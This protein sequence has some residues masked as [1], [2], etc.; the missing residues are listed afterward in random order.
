MG[1]AVGNATGVSFVGMN[2]DS[3]FKNNC[4]FYAYKRNGLQLL[5][6]YG[7]NAE[8]LPIAFRGNGSTY[9]RSLTGSYLL[10]TEDWVI[11]FEVVLNNVGSTKDVFF[12]QGFTFFRRNS[13]GTW[14]I[15]IHDGSHSRIG[16]ISSSTLPTENR[17]YSFKIKHDKDGYSQLYESGNL[18]W[19]MGGTFE[20][21]IQSR[22]SFGSNDSSDTMHSECYLIM[23]EVY[24]DLEETNLVG[25]YIFT[26]SPYYEY[27][28]SGNGRN[29]A[30]L[31][32]DSSARGY[33]KYGSTYLMDY[34]YSLWQK[35]GSL[36]IYVPYGGQS[37]TPYSG[38]ELV[39]VYGGSET[40]LNMA[41]CLIGFNE[42]ESEDPALQIF[43]RSNTTIQTD[44][45]RA[46]Q[47]YD[48]TNLATKSRY[49]ISELYPYETISSLFNDDYKDIVFTTI[50]KKGSDFSITEIIRCKEKLT[51]Y[52]LTKRKQLS[53]LDGIYTV[54]EDKNFRKIN[55]AIA[56]AYD[57]YT[58]IIDEGTYTE[59]IDLTT[60]LVNLTGSGNRGT[61]IYY[62]IESQSSVSTINVAKDCKFT[63]LII[64]KR[65]YFG[66][67]SGAKPIVNVSGC[68]PVF[69]NCQ[70]G[71]DIYTDGYSSQR[72]MTI[73]NNSLVT[74]NNCDI[75][76]KKCYGIYR[77]DLT[78]QDTSKLYFE[79][80]IFC[81]RLYLKDSAEAYVDTDYLYTNDSSFEN[82]CIY[83]TGDS[84][85]EIIVNT[86]E[87]SWN[88]DT[89]EENPAGLYSDASFGL[90]DNA[91][92]KLSGNQI[93]GA[94]KIRGAGNNVLFENIT[95][96]LGH[97]W[98]VTEVD[99]G[100]GCEIT[101]D[102]CNIVLDCDNDY[103]GLHI[104]E[105]TKGATVNILNSVLEFSGH[106]GNW[107]T[108]GNPVV[109]LGKLYMRN[110]QVID[111]CN[112]N[113]PFGA[114]YGCTVFAGSD[115]EIE[116][117]V[118][119]NR[120]WDG[121][122][123]NHNLRIDKYAGTSIKVR[124]KNVVFNNSEINSHPL[125]FPNG[126]LSLPGYEEDDYICED[127]VTYNSNQ[128]N[129][130]LDCLVG[131]R[132]DIYNFLISNCPE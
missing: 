17:K 67:G 75:L 71:R 39:K 111:N 73:A 6:Y 122:G 77:Y 56:R 12:S 44:A 62:A 16:T 107:Y 120:N 90:Y 82:M 87:I 15:Q 88:P 126:V 128:N 45:S 18:L 69:T 34:G 13:D 55:Q 112:D 79:G 63:N 48:S 81:C 59:N 93:T 78:I 8:I 86:R 105:D 32:Y 35:S 91:Y 27:D 19:S 125:F 31:N 61:I 130:P 4:S 21:V 5:D 72:P 129:P 50:S 30:A 94:I 131:N 11:N 76:A 41:P 57:N 104:I 123:N 9:Y 99:A 115:I 96:T 102:N 40:K 83:L 97:F 132:S 106:N 7:N 70:I 109:V 114:N 119:T 24:S 127:N 36:D 42:S 14:Y 110:S 98:V 28:I 3:Y 22:T 92:L 38:Y 65:E 47:Y 20:S 116:D 52:K 58:I 33:C 2:W 26:G 100:S 101:F 53:H 80:I 60:K 84:H 29:L 43:D 37:T 1:I 103:S 121:V 89:R 25:R 54:G 66:V 118:I 117:S 124:L 64:D 95:S 49:H 113:I 68:N 108:M 46:S 10:S 85:A 74:M 23:A 51:G